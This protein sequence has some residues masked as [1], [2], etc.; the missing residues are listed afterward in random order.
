MIRV[1]GYQGCGTCRK[2]YKWLG[3]QGLGFEKLAVRETP[4]AQEELSLG[5][6][7]YGL[8][9][10]FNTS[11]MDYRAMGLKDKLAGMDDQK[12]LELLLANG[13]LVKRPFVVT[14]DTILV[15]FKEDEWAEALL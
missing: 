8:R 4:P 5:M 1:Y 2:A 14:P 3:E 13:N 6:A 10:L 9:K 7:K 12:A 15:G 11:G